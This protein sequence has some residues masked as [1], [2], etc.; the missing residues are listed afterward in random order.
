MEDTP[1]DIKESVAV[2][3]ENMTGLRVAVDDM[4]AV[5]DRVVTLYTMTGAHW[6]GKPLESRTVTRNSPVLLWPNCTAAMRTAM[7]E[8]HI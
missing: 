7:T 4:L 8:V 2:W 3:R 6:T 1:E 5:E